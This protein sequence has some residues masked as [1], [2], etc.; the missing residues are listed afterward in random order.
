MTTPE[1]TLRVGFPT[2]GPSFRGALASRDF[3]LLFVGQVTAAVGNGVLQL[4]LPWLV[5]QLTD[6]ALQL[7]VA[8]FFQFLPMLLFGIAGGVFVDR[9]D[10][11]LTIVVVDAVRALAFLSVGLIYYLDALT[12]QHIYAVIFLESAM[13]N[14]FNPARAALMP[15]LVKQ[16]DL[17]AANSLMEISRHIGFIIAPPAGGV[18]ISILGASAL[19]LM[20]GITFAISAITVFL[21]GW[22]QPPRIKEPSESWRHS[23]QIVLQETKAGLAVI[24]RQRLLQVAVLLGLSLNVIIAPIQVLM[25]L[26]VKDVKDAGPSYF[27]LLVAGLLVGLIIGSLISP[28]A[29]RKLGLG[30]MTILAVV[31]LGVVVAIA[32]WPPTLWPPV[33]AMM[34]AGTCVGSLNVAQTTML[35]DATSDEERGRVSASYFTATLGIRPLSF[36]AMGA[37]ASAVDI[38]LL[39]TALGVFAV[40]LGGLLY[41]LTEVRNHH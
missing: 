39:F 20:D 25:P 31:L 6:S 8:Y 41:R 27:G 24:G 26:F 15:N 37:L 16:E 21:I 35:Q 13:A 14:F 22:R 36:L 30:R 28:S 34:I 1:N 7:G 9:F 4:A 3:S 33:V 23:V 40:A 29:S 32:S 18:L 17:R 19:F 38:R 12:V 5:L 11:R 10:R 2:K